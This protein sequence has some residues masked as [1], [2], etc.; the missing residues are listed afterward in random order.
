WAIGASLA[1]TLF[2]AGAR[3]A[4]VEQSR[5]QL[6]QAAARYR[7]TVLTA[8]QDVEDQLVAL[9]VLQQQQALRAE[10]SRAA[11]L[12]EQQVLNRYQAGQIG[13]TEVITAQQ[14]AASTRRA[15]VQAQ[16]DRQLAA[17]ALI[18]G[19]GGG[20]RGLAPMP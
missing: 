14:N 8:F 2:D 4:R 19:L 3:Q 16:I 5:A 11:D 15:L 20:W 12:V 17:V 9:R 6:E 10:A 1:Q 13:F 18:Q 7:Q